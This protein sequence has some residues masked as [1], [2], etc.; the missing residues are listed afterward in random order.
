MRP[1]DFPGARRLNPVLQILQSLTEYTKTIVFLVA[2]AGLWLLDNHFDLF[3]VPMDQGQMAPAISSGRSDVDWS[4]LYV[5]P[6][7]HAFERGDIVVFRRYVAHKGEVELRVSR[8][9]ALAGDRIAIDGTRVQLNGTVLSE[10][11]AGDPAPW[12]L[13]QIIVPQGCVYVLNDVR[14]SSTTDSRV[15]GPIPLSDIRGTLG[16]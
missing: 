14:S 12:S 9:I 4:V 13:P 1:F 2:V 5:T 15:F 10:D 7:G 3:T 16:G 6:P 11:Y 8:V